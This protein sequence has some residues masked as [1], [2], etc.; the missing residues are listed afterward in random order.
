M[1]NRLRSRRKRERDREKA[2]VLQEQHNKIHYW[3]RLENLI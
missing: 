3:M 1:R 2:K